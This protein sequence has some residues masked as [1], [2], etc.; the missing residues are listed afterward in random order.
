MGPICF[1]FP[2]GLVDL[3]ALFLFMLWQI[4]MVKLFILYENKV[5]I[6]IIYFFLSIACFTYKLLSLSAFLFG[7]A[8]C[9]RGRCI[10]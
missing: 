7:F 4:V 10:F 2:S 6:I 8:V 9:Q 5:I 3:Q 1:V